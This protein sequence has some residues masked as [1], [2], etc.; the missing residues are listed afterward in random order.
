[1][2]CVQKSQKENKGECSDVIK[3]LA[4][5]P[6]HRCPQDPQLYTKAKHRVENDDDGGP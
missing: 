1:M 3:Y 4:S 5:S 2:G 6:T